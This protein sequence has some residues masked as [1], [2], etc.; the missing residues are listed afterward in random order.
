[1]TDT[2]F[3]MRIDSELKDNLTQAA[4]QDSSSDGSLSKLL[5][6]LGRIFLGQA[7][8]GDDISGQCFKELEERV[9][10]L[11]T[12]LWADGDLSPKEWHEV[13][14]HL[15]QAQ[16][17][18]HPLMGMPPSINRQLGLLIVGRLQVMWYEYETRTPPEL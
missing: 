12:K 7:A 4:L 6:V 18:T 11:E 8:D 15:R 3:T 9:L 10:P 13:K 17:L 5:R 16:G 1:M 14:D 2:S